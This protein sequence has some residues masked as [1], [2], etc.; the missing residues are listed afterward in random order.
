MSDKEILFSQIVK[1]VFVRADEVSIFDDARRE[2]PWMFDFKRVLLDPNFL[3]IYARCILTTYEHL[4]RFQVAGL[5]S[6]ALP[7]IATVVMKAREQGKDVQGF[8]LRKSRKK[9]GLQNRVEGT[10]TDAPIILIDDIIHS[11]KSFMEQIAYMR[12]YSENHKGIGTIHGVHAILAFRSPDSY[13]ELNGE[14]IELKSIFTLDDFTHTLGIQNEIS[15]LPEAFPPYELTWRYNGGSSRY[16]PV[17]PHMDPVHV[18]TSL[19]WGTDNGTF[20]CLDS[21][22]G[23]QIWQYTVPVWRRRFV[24]FSRAVCV[25]EQVCFG[26]SDGNFYALN[27]ETGKRIWVLHEADWI[28]GNPASSEKLG[29]V[30]APLSFGLIGKQGSVTALHATTG[31][32]AWTYVLAAPLMGG[33]TYNEDL[34]LLIFGTE[35]SYVY[36]IR[37]KTGSEVWRTYVACAPR[38]APAVD[39]ESGNVFVSGVTRSG[40]MN[41]S[42]QGYFCA[43]DI[44]TGALRYTW[45]DFQFGTHATPCVWNSMVFFSALD[46]FIYGLHTRT[47][48][49]VWKRALRA[50]SYASPIVVC[51]KNSGKDS[52][53][54]GSNNGRFVALDPL[55]GTE[56]TTLYFSERITQACA[57]DAVHGILF[58]PTQG[59]S[60]Y[61]FKRRV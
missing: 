25:G 55:T 32:V 35:D 48:L 20:V 12:A 15:P 22:T 4:P 18:H 10:V 21:L 51:D 38:G 28:S 42:D 29:L 7:L 60:L 14:G 57:H 43:L 53:Y 44:H 50:R 27:R 54:I 30:F 23:N 6:G 39:R 26:S 56:L 36:A 45:R 24:S 16:A 40:D 3:D 46:G 2:S 17:L 41:D 8:F 9:S 1:Q 31:K 13:Q 49:L 19:L 33:I 59:N 61:A 47:G 11:G 5:E 58:I 34:D 37:G 52:L